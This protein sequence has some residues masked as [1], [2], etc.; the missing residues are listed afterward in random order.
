MTELNKDKDFLKTLDRGLA[1]I[2]TFGGD[3]V[4]MTLS[5]VARRNNMSRASARRFL[6][7]LQKLGYVIKMEDHFQLTAKNE[8]Y[9][10]L[11]LIC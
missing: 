7:T 2:K 8:G 9:K 3:A 10:Q 4:R 11:I 6:L 1:L 5:E